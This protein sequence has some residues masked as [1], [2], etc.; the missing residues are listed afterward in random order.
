[1]CDV[2]ADDDMDFDVNVDTN[3]NDDVSLDVDVFTNASVYASAP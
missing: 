1:M 3:A 2:D